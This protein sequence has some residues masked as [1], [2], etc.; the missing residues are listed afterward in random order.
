M[1]PSWALT[2][3]ISTK[4]TFRTEMLNA[5]REEWADLSAN[6]PQDWRPYNKQA[7]H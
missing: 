6:W 3:T 1:L 5:W 4:A 7:T 2:T